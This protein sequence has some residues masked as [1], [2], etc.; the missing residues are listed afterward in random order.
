MRRERG[1]ADC[2]DCAILVTEVKRRGELVSIIYCC[3]CLF[4][5]MYVCILSLDVWWLF[6]RIFLFFFFV[7]RSCHQG[8]EEGRTG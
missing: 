7:L 3:C 8:L 5:C 2:K 1:A 4:V 6:C